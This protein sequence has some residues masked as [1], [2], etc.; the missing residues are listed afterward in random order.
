MNLKSNRKQI[1]LTLNERSRLVVSQRVK[2]GRRERISTWQ[3]VGLAGQMGFDIALPIVGGAL[4]GTF[5][6]KRLSTYP[7]AT[8][9]LLLVGVVL[10]LVTFIRTIQEIM[11]K[12]I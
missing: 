5:L 12:K 3:Y 2:R 1:Q 11:N 9:V 10:S 7:K 6:D 8:L 4:L